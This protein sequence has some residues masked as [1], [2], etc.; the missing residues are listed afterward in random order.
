MGLLVFVDPA[1][2]NRKEPV[3]NDVFD[4]RVISDAELLATIGTREALNPEQIRQITAVAVLPTTWRDLPGSD[5][6]GSHIAQEFSALEEAVGPLT[7]PPRIAREKPRRMPMQR[8][9]R[10]S[11]PSRGSRRKTRWLEPLIKL[12]LLAGLLFV[13]TRPGFGQWFISLFTQM[14]AR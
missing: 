10:L 2:M 8:A 3:G 7:L 13:V 11:R 4:L 5:S 12:A 9:S 6:I 1:T 14:V